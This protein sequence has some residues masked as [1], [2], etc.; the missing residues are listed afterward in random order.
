[1]AAKFI[2]ILAATYFFGIR[3]LA[4][5]LNLI[6]QSNAICPFDHTP[7]TSSPTYYQSSFSGKLKVSQYLA[8]DANKNNP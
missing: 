2:H 1:M 6:D 5:I 8:V 3:L 7:T 4:K